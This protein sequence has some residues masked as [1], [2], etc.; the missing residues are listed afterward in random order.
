MLVGVLVGQRVKGQYLVVFAHAPQIESA[1]GSA[2]AGGRQQS[3]ERA[4]VAYS[5]EM[6]IQRL[7]RRG[8]FGVEENHVAHRERAEREH[9]LL[10]HD[11]DLGVFDRV[12]KG[13]L[14]EAVG[15]LN[16]RR[17]PLDLVAADVTRAAKDL[18]IDRLALY[19]RLQ[20]YGL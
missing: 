17:E 5:E 20:K 1:V 2:I 12:R 6:I 8:T 15:L 4:L 9:L 19:R 3:G 13:D 18:G 10:D 14:H 16:R 7:T 11:R